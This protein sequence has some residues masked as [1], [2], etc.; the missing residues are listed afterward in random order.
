MSEFDIGIMPL[1][2]D[3]W[4]RGKCGMKLLQYMSLEI[5]SVGSP[6]GVVQ[7]IVNDGINGFLASSNSDWENVLS[8]LIQNPL[9]RKSSGEEGRRTVVER[10]SLRNWFPKLLELYKQYA[11]SSSRSEAKT[12]HARI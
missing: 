6:V 8:E 2:D 12:S 7:E 11:E 10:Y 1:T 9:L 4:T 3:E 5:A